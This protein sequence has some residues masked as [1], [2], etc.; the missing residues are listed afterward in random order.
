MNE[1]K[2]IEII[3][4]DT[5]HSE[6]PDKT[7]MVLGRQVFALSSKPPDAWME[8]FN[9]AAAASPGRE[10]RKVRADGRRLYVFGG[11]NIFDK[12]D[13]LNLQGL[14]SYAN[15]KYRESLQE[16]DLSGLDLF[17]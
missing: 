16:V 13:A 1:W 7:R 10:G 2:P 14:V 11:P 12:S 3:R 9:V 8:L 17:G 4:R 5:Q 15:D 6:P